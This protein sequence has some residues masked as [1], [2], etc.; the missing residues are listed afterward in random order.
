MTHYTLS[1]G[2][3]E[4]ADQGRCAMEWVAYLANE[5][6]SDHP[7]CVSEVLK[8]FCIA[9]NDGLPDDRRQRLRPYLARTIG[10]KGDG[11]DEKRA[12]MC[13]DWLIRV[14]TP[15]WLAKAGLD[16]AAKRLR[17]LPPVLA[18]ENLKRAMDDIR[19]AREEQVAA[20]DAAWDAARDAAWDAAWVAARDAAGDAAWVAARD[21][22]G[23]AAWDAAWDAARDAAR[24]AAWVAARDAAW[25]ALQP[26][27]DELQDS[28]FDLL[29]AMLPTV[30][31]SMP[32]VNDP[33]AILAFA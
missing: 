23:D 20:W 25:D 3:H 27:I 30:P 28:A 1:S 4:T 24:D 19:A 29:D 14:Y 12:W 21:A 11:L 15:T 8:S 2:S 10:T 9:F 13:T 22:A 33:D 32:A 7:I 5:P 6:H 16:A 17:S 31:L 18:T 26:T